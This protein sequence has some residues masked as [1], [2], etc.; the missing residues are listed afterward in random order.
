MKTR[1]LLC[2]LAASLVAAGR[3]LAADQV[4]TVTEAV[5]IVDHGS[6]QSTASSPAEKGTKIHDGEYVKTGAASRAELQFANKTVSR[7]GANT[8]FNYSASANQVDLQAGTILF[9]KPKDGQQLNIKTEAVTAAIVGTTGFLQVSHHDGK[10]TT[11]F[12]LIEGHANVTPAGGSDPE[13]GPGQII[14]IT[15]GAPPEIFSFDVPLFLK[16]SILVTGFNSTLP[17]QSYID[18]EIAL[19]KELVARGF[20]VPPSSPYFVYSDLGLPPGFPL[21][22]WDS[23]GN[24]LHSY[25]DSRVYTPPPPTTRRCCWPCCYS[26]TSS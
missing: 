3:S 7:L 10:T 26:R 22:G 1:S 4:A 15:P 14:I 13:I 19:F 5:N 21:F 8:V 20:I 18:A 16:T 11:L 9:S 23:A 25:N 24:G 2:L 17:N 12:G 6:S